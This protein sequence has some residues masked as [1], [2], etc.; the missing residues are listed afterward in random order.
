MG[1]PATF[2]VDGSNE[3][4]RVWELEI[5]VTVDGYDSELCSILFRV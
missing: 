4:V 3:A 2:S 1:L 5:L